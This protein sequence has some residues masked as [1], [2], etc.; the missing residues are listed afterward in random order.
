M[1]RRTVLPATW[2]EM[3]R[4]QNDMNR[5]FGIM[6]S[7][8]NAAPSYPAMNVWTSENSAIISA[9]VPGIELD[10]IDISIV[11]ET[12]TLSGQRAAEDVGEG[13]RHH[14]R[15][16]GVGRFTRTIDL[17]FRVEADGVE[18]TL[19]NG[20]LEI[21]LPRAEADRPRKIKVKSV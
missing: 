20:V 1:N 9:E 8:V 5:L 4:L 12:L 19:Q 21:H 16:R 7:G 18:A 6:T 2:R 14:R 3:E 15:E 17:P 13:S 10:Y 11:G